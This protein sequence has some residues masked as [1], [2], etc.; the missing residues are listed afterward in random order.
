VRNTFDIVDILVSVL[1]SDDTL[2]G[3]LTGTVYRHGERPVNSDK[4]DVIVGC[5]PV[6]NEQLQRSV[7]NVNI[8]VPN[9]NMKINGITNSQ[10]DLAR[11]EELTDMVAA[12]VD[13]KYFS[14]YWFFVQQQNLFQEDGEA[15][16]NIRVEFY[17]ENIN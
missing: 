15:Y 13:E 8:H 11:L 9:L 17:L 16:S 7:A 10:P 1:L 14:D 6:T 2:K 12:L 3:E 5:L 4:E